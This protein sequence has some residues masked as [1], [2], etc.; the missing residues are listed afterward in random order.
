[1]R[2][3]TAKGASPGMEE[4]IQRSINHNPI[5]TALAYRPIRCSLYEAPLPKPLT[6]NHNRMPQSLVKNNI[7]LVFSTRARENNLRIEDYP[8]L[9]AYLIGLLSEEHCYLQE[10][11]GTENHIHILLALN[12]TLSISEIVRK[13]KSNTSRWLHQRYNK[14]F[15]WQEDYGAFSVSQ[16]KIDVVRK[17]IQNQIEH[18]RKKGFKDEFREFLKAYDIEWDEKYVWD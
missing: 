2:H 7:H 11:G 3:L 13:I 1:M 15:S 17:Y 14:P 12:K 4:I 9:R 5:L 8:Y 16:S 18:H 10:L 6:L